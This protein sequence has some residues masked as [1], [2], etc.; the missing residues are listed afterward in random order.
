MIVTLKNDKFTAQID[1]FGA[2]LISLKGETEYIW[3]RTAP[4]WDNCAPILFPVVGR[5]L[6]EVITVDGKDYPMMIHGF[7]SKME[8]EVLTQKD[9]EAKFVLKSNNETLTMYP[10]EFELI[11]TFVLDEKGIDT[12]MCVKNTDNKLMYFGIGGHPG[13]S[14][15]MFEGDKFE[16]YTLVFDKEYDITAIGADENIFIAPA[17]AHKLELNGNKFPLYRELFNDDAIV[18]EEAPFNSLKVLNKQNKG[19][20]FSF[21]NFKSFAMWTQALPDKAPFVC[22]EP[23][24]SMGKRV[25][26]GSN[27]KDKKDIVSLEP[28]KCFECSYKISP[29]E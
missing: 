14:C 16:D 6:N 7:A 22:L 17:T 28:T 12:K 9:E 24:N 20:E 1:T 8:F 13:I 11:V 23:W 21:E 27:L 5:A 10:F 15:P 18:I 25:G 3:Q 4:F 26:E 2:Q 19:V 29:I